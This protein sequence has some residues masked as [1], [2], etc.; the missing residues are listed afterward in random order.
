[1]MMFSKAQTPSFYTTDFVSEDVYFNAKEIATFLGISG[2]R[3]R[4]LAGTR[5]KPKNTFGT[6]LKVEGER[7]YKWSARAVYRYAVENGYDVENLP[8]FLPTPSRSRYEYRQDLSGLRTVQTHNNHETTVWVFTFAERLR[9]GTGRNGRDYFYS[10]H[11]MLPLENETFLTSRD[12]ERLFLANESTL[13]YTTA[14]PILVTMPVLHENSSYPF[15]LAKEVGQPEFCE[16][17]LREQHVKDL[18]AA[19]GWTFMPVWHEGTASVGSMIAWQPN[20]TQKISVPYSMSNRWALYKYAS[21]KTHESSQNAESWSSF[22]ENLYRHGLE[23]PTEIMVSKR[24][25][26]PFGWGAKVRL[27]ERLH[28]LSSNSNVGF[29][30]ALEELLAEDNQPAVLAETARNYYGD[31][32]YSRPQSISWLEMSIDLRQAIENSGEVISKDVLTSYRM[33]SLVEHHHSSFEGQTP[34]HIKKVT[35]GFVALS[36]AGVT[37][38]A[39]FGDIEKSPASFDHL[40]DTWPSNVHTV[41]LGES[42]VDGSIWAWALTIKG[43]PV[44]L[45]TRIPYG[46]RPYDL[47]ARILGVEDTPYNRKIVRVI[48]QLQLGQHYEFSVE[49]F[50]DLVFTEIHQQS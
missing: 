33:K 41:H 2:A 10:L 23:Y 32:R 11:L 28:K 12:A 39:W 50:K 30:N 14:R 27:P 40:Q 25:E 43:E 38:I 20:T 34:S 44:Q 48:N 5:D 26:A 1:M 46:L 18:I 17:R 7:G 4:Q 19:I 29:Y 49:E 24:L 15:L 42:K 9:A 35:Q 3:V 16:T 13:A 22:A 36:D 45:P 8:A 6:P 21:D 31:H 37:G 47:L